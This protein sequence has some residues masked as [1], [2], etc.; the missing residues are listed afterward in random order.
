MGGGALREAAQHACGLRMRHAAGLVLTA[1]ALA[2]AGAAVWTTGTTGECGYMMDGDGGRAGTARASCGNDRYDGKIHYG[3]SET[4]SSG[5][6]GAGDDKTG[7]G[8]NVDRCPFG[9][10]RRSARRSADAKN[11]YSTLDGERGGS[12]TIEVPYGD[13]NT[14][15]TTTAPGRSGAPLHSPTPDVS[16]RGGHTAG[17]PYPASC[18]VRE[19][20]KFFASYFSEGSKS[21][22]TVPYL[23]PRARGAEKLP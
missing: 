7:G 16:Q 19:L 4:S 22:G 2:A 13:Q 14:T 15:G 3:S 6:R 20:F 11:M 1:I 12:D 18:D 17:A 5:W 21:R 10:T 9:S 8:V 23:Q